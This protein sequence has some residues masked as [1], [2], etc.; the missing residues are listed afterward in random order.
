MAG[1][2]RYQALPLQSF[3]NKSWRAGVSGFYRGMPVSLFHRSLCRDRTKQPTAPS[4]LSNSD[5]T[6][7]DGTVILAF[8]WSRFIS[9]A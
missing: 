3:A 2:S 5:Q 4:T 6:T 8:E 7:Y 1:I 9:L